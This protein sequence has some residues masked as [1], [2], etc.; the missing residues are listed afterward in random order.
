M[1][2]TR[3]EPT[4]SWHKA[5]TD[6]MGRYIYA[7]KPLPGP[8]SENLAFTELLLQ[9]QTPIGAG[10]ANH[11]Q[12]R[13]Y[14]SPTYVP[15]VIGIQGLGGLIQGQIFGVPLAVQQPATATPQPVIIVQS[16]PNAPLA[17]AG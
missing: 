10:N 7:R 6:W 9:E 2:H 1:Q 5:F 15:H 12:L 8:G 3:G 17:G 13:T 11:F 4:N 14:T 16:N